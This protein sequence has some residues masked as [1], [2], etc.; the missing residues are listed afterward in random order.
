M[1]EAQMAILPAADYKNACD[2]IRRKTGKTDLIP[3]GELSGQIKSLPNIRAYADGQADNNVVACKIGEVTV[4]TSSLLDPGVE[5]TCVE[6]TGGTELT[7]S[8]AAEAGDWILCTVTTRSTTTLPSGWTVLHS[9]DALSTDNLIQRMSILCCQATEAG[10]VSFTVKQAASARIY[11]SLL[12]FSGISGFAYH[13]GTEVLSNDVADTYVV[14]RPDCGDLV[15]CVSAVLCSTVSY[16][17]AKCPEID[18][19]P[20]SLSSQSAQRRQTNFVDRG[21]G[22]T[23]TFLLRA[24]TAAII[25]CVEILT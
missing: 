13:E 6:T 16:P 7:G 15:W 18:T 12:K 10:T 24:T 14:N 4:K 17:W 20:I 25:D 11:I 21:T 19:F 8:I 22:E 9:S 5:Y 1:S 3:S 23:R 2:A